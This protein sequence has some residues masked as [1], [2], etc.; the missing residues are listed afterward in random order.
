M[1]T[2]AATTCRRTSRLGHTLVELMIVLTLL[3]LIGALVLPNYALRRAAAESEGEVDRLVALLALARERA[4]ATGMR[5]QVRFDPGTGQIE[6]VP[7]TVEETPAVDRLQ[8]S[9]RLQLERVAAAPIE[10]GVLDPLP[11]AAGD[12]PLEW[13]IT[14]YPEGIADAALVL[15]RS[16][17]EASYA[18]TVDPLTGEAHALAEEEL[19]AL[20]GERR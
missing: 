17:H 10:A 6:V 8:L 9:E 7:M 3:V 5:H 11:L 12:A 18:I 15:M 4:I 19:A 1:T 2:S 13:Q 14:F 16:D 20:V